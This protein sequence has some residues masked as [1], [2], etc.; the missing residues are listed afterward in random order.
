MKTRTVKGKL[1][2]LDLEL[3]STLAITAHALA[4]NL[5]TIEHAFDASN[6]G[7]SLSYASSSKLDLHLGCTPLI[8]QHLYAVRS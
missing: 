2:S 3:I 1:K 4:R 7:T 8:F 6:E 5:P